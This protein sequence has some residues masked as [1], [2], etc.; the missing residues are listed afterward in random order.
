[1]LTIALQDVESSQIAAIGHD[2]ET[3]TLAIRFKN[4]K[5]QATSLYH[6]QNVSVA[7][8]EALREAQSIGRHFGQHIKPF[9]DRFPYQKIVED[10]DG[11]PAAA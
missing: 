1:M 2:P 4:W 10:S 9:A 3:Q 11:L 8:F 6:Y 5:G 7:E